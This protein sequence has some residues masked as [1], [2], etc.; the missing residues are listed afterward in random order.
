MSAP[1][2]RRAHARSVT[3][4]YIRVVHVATS[5]VL[6]RVEDISIGG[7]RLRAV[8]A[9]DL[10]AADQDRA[11]RMEPCIQ[12]AA[13]TPIHVVACLRWQ[14]P[15]TELVVAGFEFTRLSPAA[16]LQLDAFLQALR[17]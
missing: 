14:R 1:D 5:A 13:L 9:A 17:R 11:L 16:V 10:G 3:S 7:F 6:G 8:A 15:D 2:E 4:S 12:G